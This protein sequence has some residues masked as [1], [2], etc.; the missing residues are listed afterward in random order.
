MAKGEGKGADQ[1]LW[2]S[3]G[4]ERDKRVEPAFK[5]DLARVYRDYAAAT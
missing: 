2:R 4:K 5:G 1:H 3:R